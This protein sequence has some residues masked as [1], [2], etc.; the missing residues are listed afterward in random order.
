MNFWKTFEQRS[1]DRVEVNN[2]LGHQLFTR[3]TSSRRRS[4]PFRLLKPV[5]AF[6]IVVG[7][8]VGV[9]RG[10]VSPSPTQ[11]PS[12]IQEALAAS[13]SVSRFGSDMVRVMVF[14][15]NKNRDDGMQRTVWV[16]ADGTKRAEIDQASPVS[17]RTPMDSHVIF[18][19]GQQ[20][21]LPSQL[22]P[23]RQSSHTVTPPQLP[24]L[25]VDMPVDADSMNTGVVSTADGWKVCV[26]TQKSS[27]D[28]VAANA[29][30]ENIQD[31]LGFGRYENAVP[32]VSEAIR[33][34]ASSPLVTDLG[35]TITSGSY[36]SGSDV[37]L[38]NG[39]PVH[40]FRVTY[41]SHTKNQDGAFMLQGTD[42]VF[43]ESDKKLIAI[44]SWLNDPSFWNEGRFTMDI[45]QDEVVPL[46]SLKSDPFD[47][48]AQGLVPTVD[49]QEPTEV[50]NVINIR[51][52]EDGC[53]T[54]DRATLT[55]VKIPGEYLGDIE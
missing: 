15:E 28:A 35:T 21:T 4:I 39:V 30:I 23:P 31:A 52:P 19:D 36:V 7:V 40:S 9:Q 53:Y 20:Y 46:A 22:P 14:S 17:E 37:P 49:E 42:Y 55:P 26:K 29:L 2:R 8:A 44:S 41:E 34:L 33:L 45:L 38:S 25:V 24:D 32:N 10:F 43:R 48:V 47:P 6:A 13:E 12:F 1:I 54:V 11:S 5:V 16:N 51:L 3:V 50:G 18:L 27:T